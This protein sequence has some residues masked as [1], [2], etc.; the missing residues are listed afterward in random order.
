MLAVSLNYIGTL[1]DGAWFESLFQFVLRSVGGLPPCPGQ[2]QVA[3]PGGARLQAA[4]APGADPRHR[5]VP[6]HLEDGGGPGPVPGAAPQL[7]QGRPRRQHF[8]LRVREG[9]DQTR[10]GDELTEGDLTISNIQDVILVN[11]VAFH[12][13]TNT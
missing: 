9:P 2:D 5:P 10:R 4:A 7:L 8:L 11:P 12:I 1:E 13:Y 3:E 6:P